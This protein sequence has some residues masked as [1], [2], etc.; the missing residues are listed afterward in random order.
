MRFTNGDVVYTT[1][2][3]CYQSGTETVVVKVENGITL[4]KV[5]PGFPPQNATNDEL[6]HWA[7]LEDC[8]SRGWIPWLNEQGLPVTFRG[9]LTTKGW[10]K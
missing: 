2:T 5:I 10:V 8:V 7:E 4:H 1:E 9:T 6:C 3:T